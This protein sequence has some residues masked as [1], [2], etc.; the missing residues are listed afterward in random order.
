MEESRRLEAGDAERPSENVSNSDRPSRPSPAV[1]PD[2]GYFRPGLVYV[3]DSPTALSTMRRALFPHSLL[4]D[5]YESLAALRTRPDN[6]PIVAALLD[7]DLGDDVK[8][9]DVAREILAKHARARIAFI[10]ADPSADRVATLRRIGP[11]FDKSHD[12][13]AAVSWLVGEARRAETA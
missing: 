1:T 2:G 12:T 8:G 9:P 7:V 13:A 11:V 4:L 10:T 6:H 5:T 3:D